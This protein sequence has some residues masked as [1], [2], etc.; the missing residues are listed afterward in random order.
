MREINKEK[1]HD[2]KCARNE[3]LMGGPI[4]RTMARK[5]AK[6]NKGMVAMFERNF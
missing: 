3:D 6:E 1:W 5:I 4:T 2:P